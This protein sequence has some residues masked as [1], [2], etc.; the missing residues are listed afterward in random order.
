MSAPVSSAT[1]L[2]AHTDPAAP[3]TPAYK[4]LPGRAFGLLGRSSLWHGPDHVLQV[5]V[6]GYSEVYRRFYF[7]D[8]QALVLRRTQSARIVSV[9]LIALCLLLFGAAALAAAPGWIFWTTLGA[10]FALWL[11]V[12]ALRGPS[13]VCH[14]RTVVEASELLPLRRVRPATRSLD[15]IRQLVEAT[16]GAVTA[17]NIQQPGGGAPAPTLGGPAL[18]APPA[19]LAP[20]PLPGTNPLRR[21]Q[22]LAVLMLAD[23][24]VST[25]QVATPGQ[26]VDVLGL[27]L[28]I[29]EFPLA[30]FALVEGRRRPLDRSLRTWTRAVLTYVCLAFGVGW[31]FNLYYLFDGIAQRTNR[32]QLG[33]TG[34]MRWAAIGSIPATLVLAVAG[35]LLIRRLRAPR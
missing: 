1:S 13:C 31:A 24:V 6:R 23:C 28:G 3:E 8:I 7:R 17:E 10:P 9:V 20:P 34:S 14:V 11:L 35:F 18:D 27:L 15:R 29:A 12:H 19:Q 25:F 4:R 16:Q 33:M 30:I 21:H 2:A 22:A 5:Q 32:L 26:L